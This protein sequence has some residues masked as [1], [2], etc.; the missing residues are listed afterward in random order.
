MKETKRETVRR[1]MYII[2]RETEPLAVDVV[3]TIK[4]LGKAFNIDVYDREGLVNGEMVVVG[5]QI[6]D[7]WYLNKGFAQTDVF[8]EK[9]YEWIFKRV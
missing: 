2:A 3:E 7:E 8:D 6:E 5:T 1:A 9:K 4:A